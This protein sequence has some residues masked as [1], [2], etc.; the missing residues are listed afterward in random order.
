MQVISY[1]N[2]CIHI[3]TR[4]IYCFFTGSKGPIIIIS[5]IVLTEGKSQWKI[6]NYSLSIFISKVKKWQWRFFGDIRK[7]LTFEK[8]TPNYCRY[9]YTDLLLLYVTP[10]PAHIKHRPN[11]E[12]ML[13]HRLRRWPNIDPTLGRCPVCAGVFSIFIRC[14]T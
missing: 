1:N 2:Y 8:F 10:V 13:V 3:Q 14:F 6:L 12:S 5:V 4:L 7:P 11:V 9:I